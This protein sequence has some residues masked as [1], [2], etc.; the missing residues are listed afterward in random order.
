MSETLNGTT[1]PVPAYILWPYAPRES[2]NGYEIVA[3][4]HGTSGNG[5]ETAPSHMKNLWQHSLGPFQLAL[6]GYVVIGTDY[7]GLGVSKTVVGRAIVHESFGGA[8]DVLYA[9]QAARSVFPELGKQFVVMGSTEGATV[10]WQCGQRQATTPIDG[11]LGGIAISPITNLLD[12]PALAQTA[13]GVTMLPA[14]EATNADFNVAGVLTTKGLAAYQNFVTVGGNY[15]TTTTL[16]GNF[17]GLFHAN[18]TSNAHVKKYIENVSVGNKNIKEPLLVIHGEL[19]PQL[20]VEVVAE[21]VNINARE[22][23]QVQIEFVSLAGVGH[24]PSNTASQPIWMDWIAARFAGKQV[25]SGVRTVKPKAA[26][27]ALVYQP[28]L[29]WYMSLSNASYQAP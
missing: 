1:V 26:R 6:Q 15:V 25:H 9:V 3:W 7:A 10:A 16:L 4:A 24:T 11:Y 18:W 13:F 2:E 22:F 5:P 21:R 8:G 20:P 28:Q 29:N 12:E 27:P 14:I 23:P 17:T 19:D